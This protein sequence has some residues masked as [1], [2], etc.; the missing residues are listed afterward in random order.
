MI[1][2]E[3]N[4]SK[5]IGLPGYSSHQFS[6][7]LRTEI[8]DGM[9]A[10]GAFI[11]HLFQKFNPRGQVGFAWSDDCTQPRTDAFG[12]GAAFITAHDIKTFNT[13]QWLAQQS[14]A[15]HPKP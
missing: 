3:A 6:I 9:D 1:T 12:G 13:T 5:K 8:A 14:S 15:L 2:L 7:T 11:R 4:Y 10:V